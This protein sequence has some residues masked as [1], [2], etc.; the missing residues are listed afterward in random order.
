MT[1]TSNCFFIFG[2]ISYLTPWSV[3]FSIG[4]KTSIR[5]CGIIS[6]VKTFRMLMAFTLCKMNMGK[7]SNLISCFV[8]MQMT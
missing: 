2:L 3:F 1:V 6:G 4:K 8:L 5:K 7:E